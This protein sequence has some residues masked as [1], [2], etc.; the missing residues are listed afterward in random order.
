MEDGPFVIDFDA[1]FTD[2]LAKVPIEI[3][4]IF[5]KRLETKYK[6]YPNFE[7]KKGGLPFYSDRIGDGKYRVCFTQSGNR[8]VMTFIGDHKAY[9]KFL[10]EWG[11]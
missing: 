11:K 8:R 3:R 4:R 10:A 2:Y 5:A 6:T 1:P 9:D 7:H